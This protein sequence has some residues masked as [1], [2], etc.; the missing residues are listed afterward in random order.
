MFGVPS[1]SYAVKVRP[2]GL[3]S[4]PSHLSI[5]TDLCLLGNNR[6]GRVPDSCLGPRLIILGAIPPFAVRLHIVLLD[7]NFAI[8][9]V[10]VKARKQRLLLAQYC[11]NSGGALHIG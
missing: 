4:P 6:H 11:R 5:C 10:F 8:F 9:F 3:G 7:G 2:D 1:S